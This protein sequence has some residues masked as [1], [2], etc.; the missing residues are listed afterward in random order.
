MS[1]PSEEKRVQEAQ[2]RLKEL[3]RA[4]G[5]PDPPR[6]GEP[7]GQEVRRQFEIAVRRSAAKLN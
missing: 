4:H 7:I 6:C 1:D 3:R 5:V 2:R